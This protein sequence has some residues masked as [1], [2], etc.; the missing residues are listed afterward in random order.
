MPSE[1][2][3]A[4]AVTAVRVAHGKADIGLRRN[5][6]RVRAARQLRGPKVR[7]NPQWSIGDAL[8]MFAIRANPKLSA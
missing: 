6:G 1:I 2:F 5:A 7:E 8:R 4:G 3:G